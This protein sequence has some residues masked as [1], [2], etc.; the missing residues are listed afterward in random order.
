LG[1]QRWGG[2]PVVG[3]RGHVGNQ[4]IARPAVITGAASAFPAASTQRELWDGYFCEHY[5]NRRAARAA[6]F[7]VGVTTR[8]AVVNPTIEDVSSSSTGA[9]MERYLAE[10]IP[11]AK[12]AVLGALDG[13]GVRA[14]EIGLLVVA[15]CTGYA[16]PGLDIL[17]ARDLAMADDLS[18]LLV[19]HVGCHAALPGLAVASDYVALHGRPAVL[20]CIELTSLHVQPPSRDLDQVVVHALF[21]D[22]ASAIVL[23]PAGSV[24]PGVLDQVG[25]E[26]CP[27]LEVLDVQTATVPGT[28]EQ[29]TWEVTDLGFRMGLARTVPDAIAGAVMPVVD[30]LL[31]QHNLRRDDVAVWA[32]HP[33]GPR[34]LDV[35]QQ[36]LGLDHDALAVSRSVL[37]RRGNCSSATI[38][39]ILDELR[40]SLVA[41]DLV[42]A[43]AFGP[44]LTINASLMRATR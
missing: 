6:F 31:V 17:L 16:T 22:A 14:D 42:L 24:R 23:Q 32:V 30:R 18:R 11:L 36:R 33:G 2:T 15:S 27:A 43:L 41:G 35:V 4:V 3:T 40:R 12:E 10:A 26:P 29:M 39:V 1:S 5:D 7:S 9:R 37:S 21:G 34:I 19:G 25:F 28:C 8:H 13:A 20:L 38:L 44:G